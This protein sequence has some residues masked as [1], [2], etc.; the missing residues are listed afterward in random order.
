MFSISE[1]REPAEAEGQEEGVVARA[2]PLPLAKPTQYWGGGLLRGGPGS[3][4]N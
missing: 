2:A 3:E 1:S 4:I